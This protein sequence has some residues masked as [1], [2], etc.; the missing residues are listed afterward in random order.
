MESAL[1]PSS[2]R[3]PGTFWLPC[4]PGPYWPLAVFSSRGRMLLVAESTLIFSAC[5]C[6][7]S[8]EIGS[9]IATSA[10]SWSK[11]F[12]ITSRAAPMPS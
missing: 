8:N 5:N 11:W 10:M 3:S 1:N 9:S 6:L 12:W 7:G 4:Q 2:S